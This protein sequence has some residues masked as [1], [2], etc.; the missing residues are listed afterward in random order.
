MATL[1]D[2]AAGYVIDRPMR[3]RDALEPLLAAFGATAAERGGGWPFRA[4]GRRC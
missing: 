3:T 2:Q 4:T 1:E